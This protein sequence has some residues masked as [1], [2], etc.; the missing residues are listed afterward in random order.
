MDYNKKNKTNAP[1]DLKKKR[2]F[3]PKRSLR[4]ILQQGIGS[5]MVAA[6]DPVEPA[7]L[8]L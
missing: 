8:L 3:P 1:K 5:S 4:E 2:D 7:N 6:R